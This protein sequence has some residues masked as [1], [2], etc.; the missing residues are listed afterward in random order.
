[1]RGVFEVVLPTTLM[2]WLGFFVYATV[3]IKCMVHGG[4]RP[5]VDSVLH[6]MYS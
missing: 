3:S 2:G 6:I 5:E 1:M 4:F